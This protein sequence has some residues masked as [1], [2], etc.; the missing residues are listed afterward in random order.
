MAIESRATWGDLVK[1]VSAK[2]A[3]VFNQSKDSYSLALKDVVATPGNKQTTLFKGMSST[4]SKERIVN[5]SGVGYLSITPEG[6][7]YN[8]DSRLPG[9]ITPFVFQKYTNSV[10]VTEENLSDRDY[11]EALGEFAD[12]SIAG[13][14]TQDKTAFG[15]FNYGF[16]AQASV[17]VNYSQYGDAKPMFSVGHPRK[18]GGTAQSNASATGITLTEPNFETARIAMQGQLDDRGKP[19]RV[20]TGKLILLVPPELE[21]T[22]VIITKG[23]KRSGTA[24]NDVNIYDGI[25]TVVSSQ[26]ISS[27]H[28]GSATAWFLIDP[29]VAK[30]YHWVREGLSTSRAIDNNTKDVTFYIK[31]RW[32][33][34][35]GD[36]RGMWGSAGDS[37]AYAL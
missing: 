5:K 19:M 24:N 32:T 1:G 26:W 35:Y 21:K 34:G 15:L 13:M 37:A 16:T 22:A 4:A 23:E 8:K 14:E 25:A 33:D 7:A 9:Y 36:W 6:Q 20:G 27:A 28:G 3:Q 2:F 30:L 11:S 29:R 18:D 17:P 31:G 10:T 12:L